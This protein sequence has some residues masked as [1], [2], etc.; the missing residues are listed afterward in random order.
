MKESKYLNW[1]SAFAAAAIILLCLDNRGVV[2][3]RHSKRDTTWISEHVGE[4]VDTTRVEF[5]K[6]TLK[7][8]FGVGPGC[9]Y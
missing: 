6:D 7:M 9:V 5:K 8:D 4:N 3:V 2:N 1:L